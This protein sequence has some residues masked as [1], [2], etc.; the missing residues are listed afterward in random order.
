LRTLQKYIAERAKRAFYN[1]ATVPQVIPFGPDDSAEGHFEKL[2]KENGFR[3]WYARDLMVALGY[4]EWA[5]FRDSV[6]NRA[7]GV[8]TTLR[9]P[10]FDHFIQCERVQRGRKIQ[11]FKLSRLACCLTAMNGDV[12]KPNVAAAQIYFAS[13]AAVVDENRHARKW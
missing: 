6:I 10:V 13:I 3:Y 2:S 5:V 7:I 12:K 11:D 4:A 8:C 1:G 9:I